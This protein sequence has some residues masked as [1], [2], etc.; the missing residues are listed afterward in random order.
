MATNDIAVTITG[1]ASGLTAAFSKATASARTAASQIT[2]AI[3]G[4][5]G[6]AAA[7]GAGLS[8]GGFALFIKS[9]IDALDRLGELAEIAGISATK[10][11]GLAFAAKSSGV[12]IDAL[13][14]GVK[15]LNLTLAAA[16]GGSDAG[17]AEAFKKLGVAIKDS[18]GAARTA[19]AVFLDVA[20]AFQKYGDGSAKAALAVALFK[21]AGT[22]LIPVLN[23]GGESLR[24]QIAYYER[25]SGVNDEIVRRAGAFNDNLDRARLLSGA[26]GKQLV[27]ELL[28][29]LDGLVKVF[30]QAKEGGDGFSESAHAVAEGIKVIAKGAAVGT[31]FVVDFGSALGALFARAEALAKLDLSSFFGIGAEEEAQLQLR[32]QQLQKVLD[33]IDGKASGTTTKKPKPPA[34]TLTG[35][36]DGAAKALLSKRIRE[37]DALVAAEQETLNTRE[38][39]LKIFYDQDLVSVADYYNTR[40]ELIRDSLARTVADY[41]AEIAAISAAAAKMT[42]G[43]ERIKA[44]EDIAAVVEKRA[45]AQR[46][47]ANETNKLFIEQTQA[48][49]K[50][51]SKI[52]EISLAI[53]RMSGDGVTAAAYGFD[54]Q[55]KELQ[56]QID[57]R[58][59]S[60]DEQERREAELAAK[61]LARLR[62]LTVQQALLADQEARFTDVAAQVG[63]TQAR[64]DIQ[65]RSGQI[66]EID[67]LNK[68]SEANKAKI[69]ELQAII[70]KFEEIAVAS[71]DPVALRNLDAM[72]LKLEELAA[73]TTLLADRFNAIFAD[74]FANAFTDVITGT[75]SVSEAFKDME[76]QIVAAISRIAAQNIAESIFGKGGSG[77]FLGD[78]FSKIFSGGFSMPAFAGGT[79]FAPGGIALVG[80]RGPELVNLPRGSRVT[81]NNKLGGGNV[82]SINVNVPGGTSRASADQIA[83]QTGAAVQRAMAR[84]G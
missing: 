69:P 58:R 50:F 30:A 15:G 54:L 9:N 6:A 84:I 22:E 77:S 28:P 7:L 68:L 39:F 10:L 45:K 23:A 37:L 14:K 46:T 2:T 24:E 49:E 40:R 32:N 48:A 63:T 66:T 1:D 59:T 56:K 42:K 25:Y 60:S 41:D 83:L 80:E 74:S 21:K 8:V 44:E 78:L 51:R 79:S 27:S 35:D 5:N 43:S 55:N 76:K 12:D 38:A 11:G 81:P 67:Y 62:E 34:P 64:L 82:I 52:E 16:V 47:A 18:S 13:S 4:V 53:A 33:A 57:I 61:Q 31:A 3:R 72:K 73:S 75:K 20:D 70:A 29:T 26:W 65:R 71:G 19:D 36:T 17:A